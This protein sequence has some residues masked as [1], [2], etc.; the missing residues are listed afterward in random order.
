[1]IT[2]Q[3]PGSGQSDWILL[4]SIWIPVKPS[5]IDSY[6]IDYGSDFFVQGGGIF[7]ENEVHHSKLEGTVSTVTNF[8]NAIPVPDSGCPC[9][10]KIDTSTAT[11]GMG[12]PGKVGRTQSGSR[13]NLTFVEYIPDGFV[14]YCF[15]N[16]Y[17]PNTTCCCTTRYEYHPTSRTYSKSY[18]TQSYRTNYKYIHVAPD[19]SYQE[20]LDIVHGLTWGGSGSTLNTSASIHHLDAWVSDTEIRAALDACVVSFLLYDPSFVIVDWGILATEACSRLNSTSVNLLEFIADFENP[21][22]MAKKLLMLKNLKSLK[23]LS[24][25]YLSLHY[26]VLPTVSDIEDV[27]EACSRSAK[28]TKDGKFR[29]AYAGDTQWIPSDLVDLKVEQHLKLA[30]DANDSTLTSI[31]A[32]LDNIGLCPKLSNLWDLVPFSFAVDWLVDVGDFLE[33][34][35]VKE[36]L[37]KFKVSYTVCSVK[38]T[39]SLEIG[40]LSDCLTGVVQSSRYHRWVVPGCPVPPT[41]LLFTLPDSNHW[42]EAG[43]LIVQRIK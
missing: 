43:A 19:Q 4:N 2:V 42:L 28:R 11:Y 37:E 23:G 7:H 18:L 3:V 26:G 36:R 31:G 9:A 24:E 27:W 39:K 15:L 17:L 14:V 12:L 22:L 25:R 10:M 30:V 16:V 5:R 32:R 35:E 41:N 38:Y 20:C 8:K 6:K 40:D 13:Y 29:L 33:R 21:V 34:S 1:M